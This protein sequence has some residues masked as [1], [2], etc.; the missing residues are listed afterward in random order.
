MPVHHMASRP[1]RLLRPKLCN[2]EKGTLQFLD[3]DRA[4]YFRGRWSARWCSDEVVVD[5]CLR[6]ARGQGLISDI[7]PWSLFASPCFL[8]LLRLLEVVLSFCDRFVVLAWI[9]RRRGIPNS[10]GCWRVGVRI[11]YFV[12]S[13]ELLSESAWAVS[14]IWSG[15]VMEER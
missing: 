9:R 11:V 3:L 6:H 14:H 12:R 2:S 8:C 4:A 1:T 7:N 5:K 10:C 13:M 15:A